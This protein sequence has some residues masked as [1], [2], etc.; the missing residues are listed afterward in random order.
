[1]IKLTKD[2][3]IENDGKRIKLPAGSTLRMIKE[4]I[5]SK[6][7]NL[8]FDG[9]NGWTLRSVVD[10]SMIKADKNYP[11]FTQSDD[12]IIF[13]SDEEN[14]YVPIDGSLSKDGY[15]NIF[16]DGSGW[17]IKGV[18]DKFTACGEPNYSRNDDGLY[19]DESMENLFVPIDNISGKF[20]GSDL[21][22]KLQS[23]NIGE[24][25]SKSDKVV[26]ESTDFERALSKI[27]PVQK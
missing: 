3:I 26:S 15:I 24:S 14:I 5:I 8:R 10:L 6:Y 9:S 13:D 25:H 18:V 1:M 21:I 12:G 22:D 27:K 20:K 7:R 11:K 17:I 23:K 4:N 16:N 19:E 2:T